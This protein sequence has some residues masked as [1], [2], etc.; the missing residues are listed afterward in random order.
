MPRPCHHW[1]M[2]NEDRDPGSF[3]EMVR[4]IAREVSESVERTVSE[5]DVDGIANMIGVDP[6]R[7]RDWLD[8]AAGMLRI[9]AERLGDEVASRSGGPRERSTR[10]ADRATAD[11]VDDPLRGAAPHPL[12]LP[13]EEQGLALAALDSGR[14]VVEPGSRTLSGEG[15]GPAPNDALGLVRELHARDWIT[16][17]GE[18]TLVGRHALSRWLDAHATR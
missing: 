4:E 13:T 11:A 1:Y 10:P 2:Y 7:A 8:T 17:D 15:D 12:D 18:V 16:V 5:V 3:E 14:W 6:D 9:Q